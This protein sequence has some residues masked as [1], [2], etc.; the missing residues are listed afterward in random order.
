M[1]WLP[2]I[3]FLAPGLAPPNTQRAPPPVAVSDGWFLTSVREGAP[4]PDGAELPALCAPLVP[5]LWVGERR[6]MRLRDPNEF[7]LL[8]SLQSHES[9]D[10]SFLHVPSRSVINVNA[11]E[12]KVLQLSPSRAVVLGVDR[13]QVLAKVGER[14]F[15]RLKGRRIRDE[16]LAGSSTTASLDAAKAQ[17]CELWAAAANLTQ[18]LQERKL[19]ARLEALGGAASSMLLSIPQADQVELSSSAAG[20]RDASS[21]SASPPQLVSSCDEYLEAG[22]SLEEELEKAREWMAPGGD[23]D[24][25]PLLSVQSFIALRLAS[26]H[27]EQQHAA[28]TASTDGLARWAAVADLLEA[29]RNE[30]QVLDIIARMGNSSE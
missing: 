15:L 13:R 9:D 10:S 23:D 2:S 17:C 27:D 20:S 4:E 21:A 25:L 29:K 8:A 5:A 7:Q 28:A 16:P 22:L 30:L 3:A 18:R 19:A 26:G 24:P 12:A 6:V 1:L 11:T 14:P